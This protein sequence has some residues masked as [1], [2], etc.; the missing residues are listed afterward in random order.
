[1]T[2][3]SSRTDSL[4]W[5]AEQTTPGLAAEA[6]AF[7]VHRKKWWLTPIVVALLLLSLVAGLS[8]TGAAP[9]MYTLF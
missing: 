6:I 2:R 4:Q 7:I 8:G 5:L 3:S 1:M 9:L